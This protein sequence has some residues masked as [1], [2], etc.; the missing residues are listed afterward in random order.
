MAVNFNKLK[1]EVFEE[2]NKIR[3]NPKSFIP[4]LKTVLGYFKKDVIYKP[5]QIP[6]QTNE[7]QKVYQETINFLEKQKP[8]A[9]LVLNENLSRAA[10]D[11]ANDIGPKGLCDHDGTLG[12]TLSDRIEKYLKWDKT[13]AENLDFGGKTG[14]DIIVSLIVDDGNPDRGHRKNIFNPDLKIIGIGIA[15]HKEFEVCTNLDYVGAIK[16]ENQ[17]GKAQELGGIEAKKGADKKAA[18]K[19]D[20]NSKKEDDEENPNLVLGDML[21]GGKSDLLRDDEDKPENAM[22]VNVKTIVKKANGRTLITIRK[23]YTLSDDSKYV[24]EIEERIE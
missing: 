11:H 10:Q 21:F 1:Q 7:G 22:D 6:L 3:A 13:I 15:K 16:S 17:K 19:T 4:I 18:K 2:H 9:A 14:E 23:T 24:V 12:M 20:K 5:G 8:L